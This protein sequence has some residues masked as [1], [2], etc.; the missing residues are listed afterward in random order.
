VRGDEELF[1]WVMGWFAALIPAADEKLGTSLV[2]RGTQGTG[3]TIVGRVIGSLL[4]HHYALVADSRYIVGRFNSHLAN[5][6]LLQLDEATWGG[7]HAAAGKLKDLITG[8]Y[9]YIEYK[10][11]EPVKVKNY[12]RL[13]VTG[14]NSWLVP[15]GLEERRFAVLDVGEGKRQDTLLPGDR[16][17]LDAAAAR[18]C[19]ATCS[20]SISP[21][22]RCADPATAA[23]A[24]QKVS[25]AVAEQH[26][27]LDILNRGTLPGRPWVYVFPSL[28]LCRREFE[29]LTGDDSS[30]DDSA[31]ERW[32]EE[33]AR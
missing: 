22:S 25:V 31:P 18:R 8:E 12:V 11:R 21:T 20:T 30:W 1:A 26:W 4:G 32:T 3:K 28:P 33:V 29:R 10:G 16:G 17:E 9:Q 5:C 15:A 13:L 23:L 19:S 6:L 2:L 24:E 7:D 27:W 14:N